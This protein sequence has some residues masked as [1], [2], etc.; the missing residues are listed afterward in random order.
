MVKDGME[1][2]VTK[3]HSAVKS[4]LER[5]VAVAKK[6]CY[7]VHVKEIALRIISFQEQEKGDQ[8]PITPDTVD[9][10]DVLQHFLQKMIWRSGPPSFYCCNFAL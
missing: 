4:A 7:P 2:L 1:E 8:K 6:Y 3:L 9:P 5:V 10:T